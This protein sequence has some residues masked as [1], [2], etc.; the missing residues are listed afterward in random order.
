MECGDRVWRPVPVPLPVWG[1][2]RICA[3]YGLF[4]TN[5]RR[6]AMAAEIVP[7]F[8]SESAVNAAWEEYVDA[9]VRF[10]RMAYAGAR[11][12]ELIAAERERM[13]LHGI[14]SNLYKRMKTSG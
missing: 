9:S 12:T 14:F 3:F 8:V 2:T 11:I 10:E 6:P 4:V 5:A 13:R 7:L 1:G